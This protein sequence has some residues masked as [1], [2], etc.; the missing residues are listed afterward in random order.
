MNTKFKTD[1]PVALI[2]FNRPECFEKVFKAVAKARPSILFLIQDGPRNNKDEDNEK[3]MACR[4]CIKID[5]ECKVYKDYSTENLG[6]GLRVFSGISKAFEIVDRLVIIEDDVVIGE[7]MLPFC[8]EMLE[9]YKNDERVGIISGMN[10]LWEY[11]RCPNSY[12]FS[13]R[14]GAI[15]G[16]AT[17]K[18]VW[19]CVEW[20]LECAKDNYVMDSLSNLSLP[21]INGKELAVRTKNKYASITKGERQTSWSTQ[22]IVSSCILQSRLYLV[23]SKNLISN[24]GIVGEHVNHSGISA[25]PRGMRKIYFAPTYVLERPLRH[26]KYMIDDSI[27][28]TEQRKVM[29]GGSF[30]RKLYRMLEGKIYKLFPFLGHDSYKK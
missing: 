21:Q 9:R 1:I 23:P 15:W 27:Y 11:T 13:A 22:F 18:R 14:G 20:N 19:D 4:D 8:S 30:V 25:I 10:H 17:W 16:W 7:D 3:V 26:P 5:W 24:I 12:F 28:Y 6:C 29:T 2:F